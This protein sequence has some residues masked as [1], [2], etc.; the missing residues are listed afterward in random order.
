MGWWVLNPLEVWYMEF[1]H[2]V[3]TF[4]VVG[5]NKIFLGFWEFRFGGVWTGFETETAK[6]MR[7]PHGPRCQN[8]KCLYYHG[9][10]EQIRW[11]PSPENLVFVEIWSR[12]WLFGF[13]EN[14]TTFRAGANL[15]NMFFFYW[16]GGVR[17]DGCVSS[18]RY[19]SWSRW[20]WLNSG[21]NKYAKRVEKHRKS[22][23]STP[24]SYQHMLGIW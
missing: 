24:H 19:R 13:L 17:A 1:Q 14:L 5:K 23:K 7:L 8:E 16:D 9:M 2:M 12:F 18:R 6:T 10:P 20:T 11:V 21:K 15:E 3:V 22:S 4:Q